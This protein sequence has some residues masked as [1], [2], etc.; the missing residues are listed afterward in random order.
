ML[1]SGARLEYVDKHGGKPSHSQGDISLRLIGL[2]RR[3]EKVLRLKADD[4]IANSPQAYYYVGK[5]FSHHK[6]L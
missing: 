1:R 5:G 6:G 4:M 3:G 2:A